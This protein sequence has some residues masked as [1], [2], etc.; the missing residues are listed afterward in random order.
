MRREVKII[1]LSYSQSQVGSYVCVLSEVNGFRKIPIIIKP[2]DAQTIALKSEGMESPRPLTHGVIK[3]IMDSFQLNCDSIIIYKLVEGIFYAKLNINNSID[4]QSID[5]TVGDAIALSTIFEC[6]LYVVEEVMDSCGILTND[7][8][9]ILEEKNKPE[10]KSILTIEDLESLLQEAIE[11]EDYELAAKYR[12][13][14]NEI[15]QKD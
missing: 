14:I 11:N 1:G 9:D 5:V 12:D 7:E 8:G 6:P 4:E 2:Q 15:N 13:K 3:S 10:N